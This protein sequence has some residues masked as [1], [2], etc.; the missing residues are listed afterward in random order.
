MRLF[1]INILILV[2]AGCSGAHAPV[3]SSSDKPQSKDVTFSGRIGTILSQ[4]CE[5]CH[6]PGAAIPNWADY[7]TVL[8][9]KDL[10]Y[11][12]VVVDKTMPPPSGSTITNEEREAIGKWIQAGAP[13]GEGTPIVQPG[14]GP[15]IPLEF[16]A[17]QDQLTSCLGCHDN[18]GNSSNAQFPRLAG[19]HPEYIIKELEAFRGKTRKVP[20]ASSIMWGVAEELTDEQISLL[21]KFFSEQKATHNDSTYDPALAKIGETLYQNGDSKREI[22]ACSL[23]HGADGMGTSDAPRLAGQHADYLIKQIAA[24]KAGDR[25]NSTTMPSIAPPLSELDVK[26][27]ANYLQSQ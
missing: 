13:I 12:R 27:L 16:K 17:V 26:A 22:M 9:K 14:G 1:L 2:I 10:I 19:Q 23:C 21:A 24:F 18:N 15:V 25:P 11:K 7:N 6:A 8:A 4:R 20:D 3:S 5:K